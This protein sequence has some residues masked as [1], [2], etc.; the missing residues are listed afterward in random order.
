MQYGILKEKIKFIYAWQIGEH[1]YNQVAIYDTDDPIIPEGMT[2]VP[3]LSLI[4][5]KK[6]KK[7]K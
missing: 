4:R 1:D 6:E 3:V 7:K 5:A 2:D